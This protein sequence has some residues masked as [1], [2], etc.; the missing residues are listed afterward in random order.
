MNAN[1][2]ESNRKKNH[3]CNWCEAKKVTSEIKK[4][5]L[6]GIKPGTLSVKLT[7]KC[8]KAKQIIRSAMSGT[9]QRLTKKQQQQQ[10]ENLYFEYE[11]EAKKHIILKQQG[12]GSFI[13]K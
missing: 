10:K 1:R 8:K 7:L 3:I 5:I 2:N 12:D 6:F 9:L 13:A 11:Q 4:T